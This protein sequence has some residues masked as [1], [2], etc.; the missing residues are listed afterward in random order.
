MCRYDDCSSWSCNVSILV[1]WSNGIYVIGI[2]DDLHEK[3]AKKDDLGAAIYAGRMIG[4]EGEISGVHSG[5][6]A[7]AARQ[8]RGGHSA[9]VH[10]D[11]CWLLL[12]DEEEMASAKR[13][14]S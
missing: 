2:E 7:S 3:D 6:A 1:Y 4:C 14:H 5:G 9:G 11:Q 13:K 8:R 10:A 12:P